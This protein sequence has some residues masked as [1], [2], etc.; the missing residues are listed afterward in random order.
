M[1]KVRM[2][3]VAV[4]VALA[5]LA[6]AA[7]GA[8]IDQQAINRAHNFLMTQKRGRFVLSYV[9]AGTT[10]VRHAYKEPVRGVSGPDGKT[11]PGHFALVYAFDWNRDGASDVAFLCDRR[12]NVYDV[13]VIYCNGIIN[14]PF[15]VANTTIKLLGAVIRESCKTEADKREVQRLID[16]ADA[17]GLLVLGLKLQQSIGN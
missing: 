5:A 15:G 14:Q 11:I 17:K 8:D 4:L 2:S 3:V 12:G 13:K 9:H 10:Y 6:P 1:R 16:N 7:R